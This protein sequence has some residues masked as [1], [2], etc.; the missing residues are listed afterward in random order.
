MKIGLNYIYLEKPVGDKLS[1]GKWSS[2][3]HKSNYKENL[4]ELMWNYSKLCLYITCI[5]Y[6]TLRFTT[7]K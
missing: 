6:Q 2:I 1:I 7:C 4:F 5:L 3:L